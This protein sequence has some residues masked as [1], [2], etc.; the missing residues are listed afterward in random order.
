MTVGMVIQ[1]VGLILLGVGIGVEIIT[2]ADL[3]YI[4]I[5]LGAAVFAVGTKLRHQGREK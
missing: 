3:W 1:L 4:A 2:H 5:T